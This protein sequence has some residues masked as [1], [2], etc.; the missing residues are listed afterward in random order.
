MRTVVD[1]VHC[2]CW[3][4]MGEKVK[5]K[6]KVEGKWNGVLLV[7]CYLVLMARPRLDLPLA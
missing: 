7:Y 6:V 4:K 2:C 1:F 5:V 3:L